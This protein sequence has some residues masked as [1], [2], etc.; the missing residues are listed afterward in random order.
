M[1][2]PIVATKFLAWKSKIVG[3]KVGGYAFFPWIFINKECPTNKLGKKYWNKT[4]NHESIHWY[5]NV[6]MGWIFFLACYGIEYLIRRFIGGASHYVAYRNV[7]FEREAYDKAWIV[8][9]LS[10]ERS[11]YAWINYYGS[12]YEYKEKDK[13]S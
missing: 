12:E 3:F 8:D 11:W 4:V 6:E 2:K 10:L 5:Q 9:Y 13:A 1:R 7:V